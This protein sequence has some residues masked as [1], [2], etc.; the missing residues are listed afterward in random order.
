MWEGPALRLSDQAINCHHVLPDL[1]RQGQV[2]PH[3]VFDVMQSAVVVMVLM[4]VFM[5][6]V[7]M[8]MLVAVV[9]MLVVFSIF[10]FSPPYDL[11]CLPDTPHQSRCRC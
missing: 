11:S 1:L 4:T 8:F 3:D 9:M 6:M 5:V 10:I 7:V 2:I